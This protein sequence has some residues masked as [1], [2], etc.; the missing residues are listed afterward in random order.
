MSLQNH[1]TCMTT[2]QLKMLHSDLLDAG[3]AHETGGKYKAI[4]TNRRDES[5]GKR[6]KI[7]SALAK[8]SRPEIDR[9]TAEF[10]R[11]FPNGI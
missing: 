11:L 4:F 6:K 1:L 5:S 9:M 7:Y 10:I 2:E 8:A 3:I